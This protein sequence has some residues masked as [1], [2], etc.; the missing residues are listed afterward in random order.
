MLGLVR[1]VEFVGVRVIEPAVS[2]VM[3]KVCGVAEFEKV[4]GIAE[5]PVEPAPLGVM[6]IVPVYGLFGVTVKVPDA[7]FTLPE[8]GP[9]K[10]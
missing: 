7:A 3:V 2:G 8:A 5:R 6:V 1:E 4:N 9:V 10:V